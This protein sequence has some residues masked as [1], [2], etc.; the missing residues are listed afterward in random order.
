MVSLAFNAGASC[1]GVRCR[2]GLEMISRDGVGDDEYFSHHGGEGYGPGTPV[3]FDQAIEKIAQLAGM[4]DGGARRVEKRVSDARASVAG[5]GAPLGFAAFTRSRGKADQGGDLFSVQTAQFRQ[6]RHQDGGDNGADATHFTQSLAEAV[7]PLIICDMARDLVFDGFQAPRHGRKHEFQ[8]F[9]D[10]GVVD[11]RASVRLSLPHLLQ[12]VAARRQRLE[13]FINVKA[14]RQVGA[15]QRVA[16]KLC[17]K[18]GVDGVGLGFHAAG[19]AKGQNG[20]GMQLG[21]AA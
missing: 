2:G 4:T 17:D 12:L 1:R 8:G 15:R 16:Q 21:D 9:S 5:C 19:L 13:L 18:R 11:K 7:E 10:N 3:L 20:I 14:A 6:V